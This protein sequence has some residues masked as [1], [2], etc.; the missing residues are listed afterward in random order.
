MTSR[1]VPVAVNPA[2]WS[3]VA[4]HAPG[5]YLRAILIA[6]AS[7]LLLAACSDNN[8]DRTQREPMPVAGVLGGEP[9]ATE[10]FARV[11][12]PRPFAFPQDH[13]PHPDYQHEWWYYTG[14]LHAQDGRRFG[15]QFTLFRIALTPM[16]LPRDSA[17]ATSQI[18]MGHFA[19]TDA[20]N[21][22]FY[23]F[24]RFARGALDLAGA[25]ARPF[26]V[27]LEDWQA[28]GGERDMF[29]LRLSAAQ[30]GVAIELQLEQTRP[31]VLQGE[32]GYSRKSAQP[33]NASYYY[34]ATRLPTTGT[35]TVDGRAVEVS[36][37][38][39]LDREWSTSALGPEQA[40]WDWFALQLDDGRDVMFYRLRNK[41]GTASAFSGGVL[42]RPD[43]STQTLAACD[44][45]I[46]ERDHW[47][48]AHSGTRYPS[49]W[50]LQLP[51]LSL[52]VD[53]TPVIDDQEL[54]LSVRYWEGAVSVTGTNA[55]RDIQGSGYV[56]LTGY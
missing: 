35:I 41:D 13:G 53:V 40:G 27:W 56:E 2:R 42:V 6:I 1:V 26:R 49:R 23:L 25:Q 43:G 47:T 46:E 33:G 44:G 31:L 16:A 7:L 37:N 17:W 14:N 48:S 11:T 54:D 4:P 55:G 29:P 21:R 50:R 39:W 45:V 5:K 15:F 8:A 36:G 20:R 52:S 28:V 19:L 22:R 30:D 38:S 3:I 32:D 10:G 18:Y 24:E 12:G 34:S 51:A 9:S